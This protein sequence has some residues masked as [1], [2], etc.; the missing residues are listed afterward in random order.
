M[1]VLDSATEHYRRQQILTAA[2]LRAVKNDLR[3]GVAPAA[4]TLAAFQVLIAQDAFDAVP[5]MLEEQHFAAPPV[6]QPSAVALAGVAS[7]GRELPGLLQQIGTDHQFALIVMTQLQDVARAALSLAIASRPDVSGYVRMLNPP[8]C[9]RC[10]V[11][12]GKWFRWNRGFQRHPRCDCRHIPA[13][14]DAQDL[15]TNP[16]AYFDSL[17]AREQDRIFTQAGARAVRDGA[18]I[19]QVVNARRGMSTAQINQRGWIPSGRLAPVSIGG[20]NAFVSSEGTTVRGWASRA[21][22]GR[23]MSLRLMPETIYDAAVDRADAIR[24]LRLHGYIL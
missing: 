15:R 10:A 5:R 18:D 14:E 16:A 20:R 13:R 8:S 22:T 11:L 1:L 2:G 4:R 12:A 17:S 7:D 9:S 21:Q 3:R 23:N 19:G 6:G 24:L